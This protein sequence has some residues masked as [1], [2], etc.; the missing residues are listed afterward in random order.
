MSHHIHLYLAV[1]KAASIGR[2]PLGEVHAL[3]VYVRVPEGS[4]FDG[5]LA[6]AVATS[7][8]WILTEIR[9]ATHV[10]AE[11]IQNGDDNMRTSFDAAMKDGMSVLVYDAVVKDYV[12]PVY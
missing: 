6:E 2:Y 11:S 8:G 7:A 4:D 3:H 1:G 9:N 10:T 12:P 5:H